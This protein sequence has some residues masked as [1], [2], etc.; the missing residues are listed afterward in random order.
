MIHYLIQDVQA[1][2]MEEYLGLWG[3]DLA[4]RLTVRRYESLSADETVS[5]GTY[6]FSGVDQLG[7][8]GREVAARLARQLDHSPGVQV[9]NHPDH[10]LQRA[11]LLQMLHARGLNA[12]RAVPVAA[13]NVELRFP[14]FLRRA[15]LHEGPLSSL[16]H[17]PRELDCAIGWETVRGQPTEDLLIVEY[18]DTS[19][20]G[21]FRKYAAFGVGDRVIARSLSFGRHWMRKHAGSDFTAAMVQEELDYVRDNPHEAALRE[22]FRIA[23]VDYGRIDYSMLDGVVQTWEINL[24][25]TIGRGL[26]PSSGR[27]PSAL[28]PIRSESKRCFYERF[29]AALI[30][31][32]DAR[33]DTLVDTLVDTHPHV[34]PAQLPAALLDAMRAEQRRVPPRLPTL[35][36]RARRRGLS[37]VRP[38]LSSFLAGVGRR[39]RA[40]RV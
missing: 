40:A 1:F 16:L 34:A 19:V 39:A 9:L 13:S 12:F 14:V 23:N 3:R 35:T 20:G 21:A 2:T 22:I 27:V 32:D 15:S 11:A 36:M 6:L 28:E 30:A 26:R 8:A 5:A 33:K 7:A 37:L 38:I 24:N 18:L 17:T 4:D 25:P 31:L 10:A 29:A